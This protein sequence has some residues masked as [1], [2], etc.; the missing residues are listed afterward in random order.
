MKFTEN[1]KLGSVEAYSYLDPLEDSRRF[2]TIDRQLL[3][4]FQVFGNGIVTGWTVTPGSGLNVSISPGRG[5]VNF[6]SA[7]TNVP[8]AISD[9]LPNAINYIY[10]KATS[11]TRYDRNPAF[12]SDIVKFG[13]GEQILLAAIT[14]SGGA[15]IK[16][17]ITERNEIG[18][19]ETIKTLISEHKHRGGDDSSSRV[20]LA[21]EVMGAL[22][23]SKIDGIPASKITSGRIPIGRIPKLKHSDLEGKGSLTHAQIDSYVRGL[24]NPNTR[25]LGELST[26]NML[27]LYLANKHIWNEVDAYS[28]NLLA[29]IPG[30]SPN[31]FI[32]TVN[33]TGVIDLV[34]HTISG[35]VAPE[36]ETLSTTF[37]LYDHFRPLVLAQG[38]PVVLGTDGDGAYLKIT[39]PNNF[40][41]VENFNK[42]AS[43]ETFTGWVLETVATSQNS[44][45]LSDTE[46]R[47]N[48]ETSA[49]LYVDQGVRLQTTKT[50]TTTQD[51][52]NYNQLEISIATKSPEHGQLKFQILS[53]IGN[54]LILT[55][56][57]L[58]IDSNKIVEGTS[59]GFMTVVRDITSLT[60][61]DKVKAIRIYTDTSLGWDLSSDAFSFNLDKIQ[62]NNTLYYNPSGR[63]KFRLITPSPSN[64]SDISWDDTELNGGSISIRARTG[65]T[66]AAFSGSYSV[67]FSPSITS[68]GDPGVEKNC[69][70][71][72]EVTLLPD[73]DKLNSPLFRSLTVTYSTEATINEGITIDTA[74]QFSAAKS[75]ENGVVTGSGALGKVI[76]DGGIDIGHIYYSQAN[77]IQQTSITD[78]I[79]P[80]YETPILGI[81][82]AFLPL[83]PLQAI[84]EAKNQSISTASAIERL[85]DR[86][87]LVADT[88]NDRV[89]LFDTDGKAIRILCTNNVTT[90]TELYP[91]CVSYDK[92]T[93][94]LYIAWSMAVTSNSLDLSQATI[95]G[96]GLVV[97][98]SNITD[99]VVKLTGKTSD[100]QTANSTAVILSA[101]HGNT[102]KEFVQG[103][104]D[105]KRIYLNITTDFAAEKVAVSNINYSRLLRRRG[106][107]IFIGDVK[108][109]A[110]I[111][112]PI[113]VSKTTSGNYLIGNAKT[114]GTTTPIGI[115]SA[116]E[117]VPTTGEIVYSDNSV[118]FSTRYL[119]NVIEKDENY[120]VVGGSVIKDGKP[121]GTVNIIDR[122]RNNIVSQF[123]TADGTVATDVQIDES[124]NL[125]IV[126]R[127]T[128]NDSSRVITVDD[129]LN[130]I[131]QYVVGRGVQD[132]RI[133]STGNF[134][135]ST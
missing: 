53:D 42:A 59:T 34:N 102:I 64:W 27:Q 94:T 73:V 104:A 41:E 86:T 92:T 38:N 22:P 3:G 12:F 128:T 125:V 49:K 75:I 8:H 121:R 109:V 98:L 40:L 46:Y 18:F 132:V 65:A 110:G 45:F 50:F 28:S 76:I 56:D 23:G 6:I 5:H 20:D 60:N 89:I 77:Q 124:E 11:S 62:L 52:T 81:S 127:N 101:A 95:E 115:V 61:I 69:A 134:L 120:L 97:A 33:S 87:Y 70:I 91:L 119:G 44:T 19:I 21:S 99:Q 78:S 80:E 9:L 116:I 129:E 123:K 51:W 14:T 133:L 108:Y 48:G 58:L 131:F 1:Y 113:C 57:F 32:D 37:N 55:D 54:G 7:E 118:D 117:M 16:I 24:S 74:D 10:A 39:K 15:V 35:V 79:D 68:G 90:E 36:E 93:R 130:V 2:M 66:Y 111:Y 25:L 103:E 47:I 135:I 122:T 63:L 114:D 126:E 13:Q 29:I 31:S 106:L 26:I 82:G 96:D 17:D 100:I 71:E 67:E 84:S 72:I 107:P 105:D 88:G 43:G 112:R 83:S 30:I 4:L 85:K